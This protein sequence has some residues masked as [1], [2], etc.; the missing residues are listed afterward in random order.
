MIKIKYLVVLLLLV[1][2]LF[3]F[4]NNIKPKA[5]YLD[6]V[7]SRVF[8]KFATSYDLAH[9]FA[10]DKIYPIGYNSRYFAYVI[11]YNNDPADI[12][13]A[14][15]VIQDLVT[16]KVKYINKFKRDDP[17]ATYSFGK[18]WGL[19]KNLI[20][21]K[22]KSFNINAKS[23]MFISH[24]LHYN[25]DSYTLSSK[26]A[27]KYSSD[28]ASNFLTSSKIYIKSAKKGSKIINKQYYKHPSYILERKP[29]GFL[30]LGSNKRVAVLVGK[31]LRGWEGPPNVISYEIVGA[32]LEVGFK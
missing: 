1:N 15:F 6:S 32:N 13:S 3:G 22:L 5:L 30:K 17:N 11:E 2:C 29:I 14:N 28:F 12:Y 16:D 4:N 8:A 20:M 19:K 25:R 26:R 10:R 7:N 23:I 18:Y 9:K 31:V 27:K 24:K 21:K